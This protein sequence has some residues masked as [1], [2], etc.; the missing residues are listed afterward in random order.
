MPFISKNLAEKGAEIVGTLADNTP[1]C[2]V[3]LI[4]L[5]GLCELLSLIFCVAL[6]VGLSTNQV[7]YNEPIC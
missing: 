7:N 4:V 1:R 6:T 5:L 2:L 3:W